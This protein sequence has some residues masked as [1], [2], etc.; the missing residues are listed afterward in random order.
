MLEF[1]FNLLPELL[2]RVSDLRDRHVASGDRANLG[3]DG[4][5]VGEELSGHTLVEADLLAQIRVDACDCVP[6][7]VARAPGELGAQRH[8][9]VEAGPCEDDDVVNVHP[10]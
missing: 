2:D 10:A 3:H 7:V 6:H 4:R 8:E 1:N 9:E 5:S